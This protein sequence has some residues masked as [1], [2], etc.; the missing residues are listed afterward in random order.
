MKVEF[1]CSQDS[2]QALTGNVE[3]P[4]IR[5]WCNSE[6]VPFYKKFKTFKEATSFSCR[7]HKEFA[8]EK[9]VLAIAGVEVELSRFKIKE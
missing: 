3:V 4:E 2:H 1:E 9:P 7:S 6:R 5:V 8:C